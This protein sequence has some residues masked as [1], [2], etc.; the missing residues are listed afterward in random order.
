MS[1]NQQEP[2]PK[3]TARDALAPVAGNARG[4][5]ASLRGKGK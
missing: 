1:R 4:T 5:A 3:K 2:T